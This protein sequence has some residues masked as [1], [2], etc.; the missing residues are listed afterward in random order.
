MEVTTGRH[1]K[2][3]R[4]DLLVGALG[5][6]K[7]T[8]ES[9]GDWHSIKSD[10]RMQD[11][12][13][14]GLF[15]SETDHSTRILPHPTFLYQGHVIRQGAK[16]SMKDFVPQQQQVLSTYDCPTVL[17]LGTSMSVG[18]TC[19]ARVIIQLLKNMGFSNVV[20]AKLSGAGCFSDILSMH[21]A[22]A[23]AVFD[24]VDAGLPSTVGI[25]LEQYKESLRILLS[26]VS[27][28][29]PNVVVAEAGASPFESYNDTETLVEM[30]SRAKFVVLCATDAYAV[31]GMMHLLGIKL[32]IVTGMATSTS[33][34][35]DLVE[36]LTGIPALNLT[37][38]DSVD[39]LK[40]LLRVA[41]KSKRH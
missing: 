18:K 38:D 26:M 24:F 35:V 41:L 40:E 9:V 39:V 33:A 14:A 17:I 1:A 16:V 30:A 19:T 31:V 10:G 13:R 34:G 7:A 3:V 4:G 25:P 2:L 5:I 29:Q 8:L 11:L 22:G 37:R 28:Q 36:T 12:T 23:D 6:R 20:G 27:L 15:G 21:D 32:D